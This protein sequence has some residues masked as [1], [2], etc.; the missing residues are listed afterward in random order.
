MEWKIISLLKRGDEYRAFHEIG[1]LRRHAGEWD[2]IG[3]ED[4]RER[5]L[6]A[7]R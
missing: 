6:W 3:Q 1:N 7:C 2:E 4:E 5:R